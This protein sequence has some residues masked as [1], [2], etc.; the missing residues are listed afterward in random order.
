M[1]ESRI[2]YQLM[3]M[4]E[5]MVPIVDIYNI[6]EDLADLTRKVGVN[7]ACTSRYAVALHVHKSD[8]RGEELQPKS[9]QSL[10]FSPCLATM[11]TGC[12]RTAL[13]SKNAGSMAVIDN[14]NGIS[15][16]AN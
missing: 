16:R 4:I 9:I 2:S 11:K 12:R 15:G 3:A 8:L 10:V 13:S 14:E 6:D 7:L 5:F 1:T